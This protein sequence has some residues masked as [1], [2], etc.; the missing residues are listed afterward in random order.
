LLFFDG[1]SRLGQVLTLGGVLFVLLG[2]LMNRRTLLEPTSLVDTLA[3][4]GLF[5]CGLILL[6]GSL[7]PRRGRPPSREGS[8]D[9]PFA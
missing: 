8:D 3:M 1:K 5:A 9:G 6:A 7:Q 2:V 4:L